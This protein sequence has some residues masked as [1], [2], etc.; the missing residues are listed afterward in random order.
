MKG[1]GRIY[2]QTFVD[3]YSSHAIVKLYDTKMALV[4]ADLLKRPH[5]AILRGERGAAA[6][7]PV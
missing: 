7:D 2:Q 3:T 4:E 5:A 6:A 1:V